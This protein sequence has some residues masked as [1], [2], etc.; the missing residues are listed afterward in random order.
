MQ[1]KPSNAPLWIFFLAA[2]V[3]TGL[4]GLGVGGT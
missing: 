1:D 3:I 2:C 4:K